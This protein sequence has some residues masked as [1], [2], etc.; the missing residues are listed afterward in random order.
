MTH[1]KY[2]QSMK[3]ILL[4]I[5]LLNNFTFTCIGQTLPDV[6]INRRI[7]VW[8]VTKSMQGH[9]SQTQKYNSDIDVWDNV[10]SFLKKDIENITDTSTELV[11]L[12]FQED[13]LDHWMVKATIE[14]KSELI[15][16]INE[17]K[18]RF[19][20]LSNTNIV[21]PFTKAKNEYV[22]P[23]FNN[24][25]IL[26]TD[27]RQSNKFGGQTAWLKLLSTWQSFAK[28]N[29]AYLI[30]FM[31]TEAAED[32]NIIDI[33][34][35]KQYSDIVT[36]SSNIPEF[37]DITPIKQINFNIKDDQ[38]AGIY[39]PL[40]KS[41]KGITLAKG[42]RFSIKSDPCS[43]IHID[44][45]VEVENDMLHF[46]LP[47]SFEKLKTI[48]DTEEMAHIPLTLELLN[49]NDIQQN[50]QQKIFLKRNTTDLVLIN[51]IEKVLKISI[52]R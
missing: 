14:G 15:H 48:L 13:I 24:L 16:K 51:K 10:V 50:Y 41:K 11:M 4:I 28:N 44:Q 1:C 3:Q 37:I 38:E 8:D 45:E 47:Y 49:Q 21:T 2:R 19:Q 25:I 17:S 6:Q 40:E 7:Y 18:K 33:L 36:P 30:Y 12:P 20:N 5:L 52:K 34:G 22:N 23:Q 43:K 32:D 26:L 42:I 31:V 39:I 9:D 35:H 27:G 29:N 46:K